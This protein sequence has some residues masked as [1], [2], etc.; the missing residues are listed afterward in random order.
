MNDH[1]AKVK[2]DPA[3]LTT[4]LDYGVVPSFFFNF[5]FDDRNQTIQ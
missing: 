3:G 2:D 1:I 5:F 4:S